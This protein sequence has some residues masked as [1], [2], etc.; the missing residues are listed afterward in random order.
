MENQIEARSTPPRSGPPEPSEQAAFVLRIA[1]G[2]IDKMPAALAAEQIII[3][4]AEAEGLLDPA[5]S[6]DQ[7]REILRD[8]YY[9]DEPTRRKAGAAAGHM[10]RFIREMKLGDLV[11]VPYGAD[12]LVAEI[13]GPTT[14]DPSKVT[15]DSA[16]R[17]SV[18]WLNHKRSIPRKLGRSA[19]LSRMKIQ[20]TCAD[21]K[22]LVGEIL[23][24]LVLAERGDSPTFQTDLQ[25]RLVHGVLEELHRG[26]I[27]NFGFEL[28]IETVLRGLGAED[29][30]IVPRS[31]DKGADLVA[32]FRVAGTFQQ[33]VAVQAK[34][35][36][37]KPPVGR[38]VV[39][40]LIRGI[41]AEAADLGMVVTSGSISDEAVQAAQQYLDDKGIR[42]ELVDGE[43]LA[44][45]IV[46]H[47]IAAS[48]RGWRRNHAAV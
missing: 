48:F 10:W 33:K 32:I 19:L 14:Y 35:W 8:A 15:D 2:G 12:F 34:H 23:E 29:V 7:F 24:C 28:L 4:W 36:Q 37:P 9:S 11:V 17:R 42:I 40:Q 46:E 26:R 25:L 13:T 30:R 6:W 21:A 20:G 31:Q 47:G 3:G 39:E 16:Y 44:K 45:L 43:L 5:L 1:P 38:D 18:N 22:D 27:E 41:E